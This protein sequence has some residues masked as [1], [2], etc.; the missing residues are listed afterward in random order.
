MLDFIAIDFENANNAKS[1]ACSLGIAVVEKGVI[2][3]IKHWYIKPHPFEMGYYQQRVHKIPLESLTLAPAFDELWPAVLPFLEGKTILAHN[4]AYDLNLLRG[5]FEH[6][7]LS[8]Q[9]LQYACTVDMAR[10][11]WPNEPKH[12]L[13]YLAYYNQLTFTHHRADDDAR[14]CAQLALRMADLHEAEDVDDLIYRTKVSK[15]NFDGTYATLKPRPRTRQQTPLIPNLHAEINVTHPFYG[16]SVVFT[17]DLTGLGRTEAQQLVWQCGGIAA[18]NLS[19]TTHYMVVGKQN[20]QL[21]GEELMSS[22]MKKAEELL[23]RGFP[24][25]ILNEEE[26][27]AML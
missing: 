20:A 10:A 12:S 1:S 19:Y 18:K 3:D 17:G 25:V 2:T 9:S 13:G 11:T 26:F 5:L 24:L 8:I 16:K 21:V 14:V 4:A 27:L 23:S 15:R 7:H 6:Y 22:K